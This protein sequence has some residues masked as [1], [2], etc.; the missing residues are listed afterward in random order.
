[1]KLTVK[2]PFSWAHQGVRVVAYE[3]GQ[4]IE[5]EEEDLIAV[6]V[7]EKWAVAAS[8]QKR[9]VDSRVPPAFAGVTGND[10]D[11]TVI[12]AQAGTHDDLMD[13]RVRGNDDDTTVVTDTT[14]IPAQAGTV[15]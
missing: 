9:G 12:P 5:T 2:K 8:S 14:V 4:E 15:E 11:T 3:A 13:S 10:D 7:K 6:A 1:M